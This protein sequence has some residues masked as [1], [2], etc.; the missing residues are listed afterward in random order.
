VSCPEACAESPLLPG[1]SHRRAA[2]TTACPLEY[3]PARP[4]SDRHRKV[5][6][7]SAWSQSTGPCLPPSHRHRDSQRSFWQTATR[8][9]W[10]HL[11]VPG[12]P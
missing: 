6:R 12:P 8:R 11:S 9:H 3:R 10:S 4:R 7:R 1:C 2:R 5:R